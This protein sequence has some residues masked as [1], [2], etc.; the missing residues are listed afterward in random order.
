M[1][2]QSTNA[3]SAHATGPSS[4]VRSSPRSSSQPSASAYAASTPYSGTRSFASSWPSV[5]G[6]RAGMQARVA[7]ASSHGQRTRSAAPPTPRTRPATPA[8]ASFALLVEGARYAARPSIPAPHATSPTSRRS[9]RRATSRSASPATATTPEARASSLTGASSLPARIISRVSAP[10][11]IVLGVRRSG[12]T[13]LRVMLDRNSQL[14]VP[15]ESYFLPQLAHRHSD[16]PDLDAFIADTEPAAR[17][18]RAAPD[19]ARGPGVRRALLG[20]AALLAL[21][22]AAS[23]AP[24]LPLGHAGRWITDAQGRVV[25]LHGI[26][27]VYKRPPYAPDA[28]GFGDDDAAFLASEGFNAVRARGDLQGGRAGA[29]RLRRRLPGP[30]PRDGRRA[31]GATASSRCSTSTR[32]STTSASRARAGPTGR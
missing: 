32:T 31:R 10:P 11:L 15:D 2:V 7:N 13:L 17:Q 28:V 18:R 26:N 21:A 30:H 24:V 27:M 25:N 12:T 23:A 6:I 4:F 29:G 8:A 3:A 1:P 19:A 20:L 14:A 22:P 9:R 16:R 5:T